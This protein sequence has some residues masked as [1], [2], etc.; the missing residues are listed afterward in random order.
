M[1]FDNFNYKKE[2][3]T[4]AKQLRN[5]S[6]LSEILLWKHLLRAR[7]LK[8]YQFLR[9]RPISKYVVDFFSKDL[10]LIIELDGETHLYKKSKDQ[11]RQQSLKDLGYSILRF[12]DSE[13]YE[14]FA[15][16]KKIL[17]DWIEKYEENNPEVLQFSK[18]KKS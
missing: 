9:Q 17:E 14:N 3:K 2:N 16:V 15:V 1:K 11:K 13:I 6:T 8:G 10:K 7:G 12:D 5:N 18:R 4:F